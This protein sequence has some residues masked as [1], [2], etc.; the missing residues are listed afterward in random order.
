MTK[1]TVNAAAGGISIHAVDVARGIPARGLAVGLMRLDPDPVEIASGACAS[2]GH[3][4]HPVSEGLG[5]TRGMYKVTFGVG[6]YYRQSGTEV[7]DPAFV[8][9]AVFQFGIERVNEHFHLPFKFTP[10]GFSLF[11]GGA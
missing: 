3:F 1:T 8:E 11:R 2:D 4:I 7:P 9:D 5:V 6:E 10:W